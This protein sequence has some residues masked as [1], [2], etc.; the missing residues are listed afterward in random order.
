M[1][2][3]LNLRLRSWLRIIASFSGN[4]T[5][6]DWTSTFQIALAD[7]WERGPRLSLR[8]YAAVSILLFP[9]QFRKKLKN[10]ATFW[11]RKC[12][13]FLLKFSD[14]T[15]FLMS[16][17]LPGYH[18]LHSPIVGHGY[19]EEFCSLFSPQPKNLNPMFF[20]LQTL[21]DTWMRWSSMSCIFETRLL[22]L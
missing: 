18:S 16:A 5:S 17:C 11:A 15:W 10:L 19:H 2:S 1:S 21:S 20:L 7:A 9:C 14:C 22:S 8:L 12:C 6:N 13:Y 3:V 4:L